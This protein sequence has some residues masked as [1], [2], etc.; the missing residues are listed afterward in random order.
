MYKRNIRCVLL[1]V[2]TI[3]SSCA[4]DSQ[5]ETDGAQQIQDAEHG[6]MF[7]D[8]END[9]VLPSGSTV[10]SMIAT[11]DGYDRLSVTSNSFGE[12]LRNLP[13]KPA[14]SAV[15]QHDGRLKSNQNVHVAVIDLE[16]G[17]KDLHQCADAV[18]RL[19]AEYL[20]KRGLYSQ[21]HFNFTSGFRCDYSK[22]MEGYR[23]Q[24][25]GNDAKWFKKSNP[26][27]TYA[28][29]WKYME[30]VFTYA[31][32]ASL[33]KELKRVALHD[34]Q[35]GDV[36]IK[37]GFPGHAVVVVDMAKHTSTGKRIFLLAQSY[38]PAQETHV[39]KNPDNRNL[40]PW[41]ELD[42]DGELNTPEW[43]FNSQQLMR[44]E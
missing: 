33:S 26:S 34:M 42:F 21:I 15:K 1:A 40:S 31:G 27:N 16:I 20:W 7:A 29:F 36:F 4:P 43:T 25:D 19:R 35:I 24:M 17:T 28:D 10:A 12:F 13:V 6:D 2:L 14:G 11:P 44:F 3:F 30:L 23:I 9:L 38:M 37:G 18:M 39:L 41:Y 32:T 22:W 8:I 5:S